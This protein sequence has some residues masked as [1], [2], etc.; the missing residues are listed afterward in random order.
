MIHPKAHPGGTLWG[1]IPGGQQH[2]VLGRR[3]ILR[4]LGWLHHATGRKRW[5]RGAGVVDPRG[6]LRYNQFTA[7]ALCGGRAILG[8]H[9]QRYSRVVRGGV[10]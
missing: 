6:F 9:P 1:C 8:R 5:Q 10:P 2:R 3:L 4:Q 7:P